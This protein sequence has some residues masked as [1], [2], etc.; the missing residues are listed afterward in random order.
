MTQPDH[1]Y[2]MCLALEQ[3]EC[4][5]Q[6]GEVPVGAVCVQDGVVISRAFNQPIQTHDPTGHAEILALR[7]AAQ[8]LG[9]Y[10][11]NTVDLYVTLQPC[12]MCIGAIV[13]ARIARVIFGAYDEKTAGATNF[14]THDH[15]DWGNHQPEWIGGILASECAGMLKDFFSKRR[16]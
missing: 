2:F 9:N 12:V 16:T 6:H 10:R 14:L 13:H 1:Q 8:H 3:A 5:A 4:A 11:L 15:P 7:A